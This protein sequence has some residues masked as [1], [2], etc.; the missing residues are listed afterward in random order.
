MDKL[1]LVREGLDRLLAESAGGDRVEAQL[2][3]FLNQNVQ[4]DQASV[5]AWVPLVTAL[6]PR[7]LGTTSTLNCNRRREDIEENEDDDDIPYSPDP[8]AA[9]CASR[10]ALDNRINPF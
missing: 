5:Y 1:N 4:E 10:Q 8:A 7:E 3:D 6:C 9:S 2:T